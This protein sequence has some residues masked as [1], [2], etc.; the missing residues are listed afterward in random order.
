MVKIYSIMQAVT[1]SSIIQPVR[2]KEKQN[3]HFS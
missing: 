2:E 3:L 1:L